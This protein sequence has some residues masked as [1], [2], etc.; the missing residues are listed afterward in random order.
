MS[1]LL[2]LAGLPESPRFLWAVGRKKQAREVLQRVMDPAEVEASTEQHLAGALAITYPLAPTLLKAT[3]TRLQLL[4]NCLQ[5]LKDFS[6]PYWELR[7]T[8]T[9]PFQRASSMLDQ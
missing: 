9:T 5:T 3:W 8:T 6:T 1:S 7:T 2:F 4:L